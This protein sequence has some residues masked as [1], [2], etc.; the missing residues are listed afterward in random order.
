MLNP[1]MFHGCHGNDMG[2]IL[3][4]LYAYGSVQPPT[5]TGGGSFPIGILSQAVGRTSSTEIT[6]FLN[7]VNEDAGSVAQSLYYK[8]LTDNTWLKAHPQRGFKKSG[9]RP[10]V[11]N[12]ATTH[13]LLNG[14]D[15]QNNSPV[16][17]EMLSGTMHYH[18]E[19][20]MG[21]QVPSDSTA[22]PLGTSFDTFAG[23][24]PTPA[25]VRVSPMNSGIQYNSNNGIAVNTGSTAPIQ[26]LTNKLTGLGWLDTYNVVGAYGTGQS[27]AT[28]YGS[29]VNAMAAAY[30]KAWQP[31][32]LPRVYMGMMMLP[33]AY[34]TEQYF[35]LIINHNFSF[36]G[37]R[38]VS[39]QNKDVV[40]I[41]EAPAY[42]N[43]N[44]WNGT[45][46]YPMEQPSTMGT[47]QNEA[48]IHPLN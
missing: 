47:A 27:T 5:V 26:F 21:A 23:T 6:G 48:D 13:Q 17:G 22:P 38:G 29:G 19:G 11:Y 10:L 32:T 30:G 12:V 4:S 46:N 42:F 15:S 16:I 40:E 36:K 44:G 20:N 39:M 14:S 25:N 18:G 37:F 43:G 7:A 28:E 35:R 33:P 3:N 2:S 8:A 45:T 34:K 31:A 24:E 1:I 9:L 41:L